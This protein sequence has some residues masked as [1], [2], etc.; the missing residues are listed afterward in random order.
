MGFFTDLKED[1]S[2]AVNELAADE[3]A[4]T[5]EKAGDAEQA[6]VADDFA[7]EEEIWA[8]NENWADE[9]WAE[10]APAEAPGTNDM[11]ERLSSMLDKL[12]EENVLP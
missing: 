12:D 6:A 10:E 1:L 5:R 2:Q 4:G 8:E 3:Q 11:V 7:S 9:D